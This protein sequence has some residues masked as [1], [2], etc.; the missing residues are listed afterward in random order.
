[1]EF[2]IAKGDAVKV[3]FDGCGR[4]VQSNDAVLSLIRKE[5]IGVSEHLQQS[6]ITYSH[7]QALGELDSI[8][9]ALNPV[10]DDNYFGRNFVLYKRI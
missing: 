4:L 5:S 10:C 7:I 9:M 3:K 8:F 6:P 1:V 2:R